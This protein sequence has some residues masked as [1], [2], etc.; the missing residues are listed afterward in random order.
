MT[1]TLDELDS[2]LVKCTDIVR[3]AVD[4][5]NYKDYIL[6]LVYYKFI[7]D[8]FE[9]QYTQN[10]Q[11]YGEDFA[12][13]RN[14]YTIPVVPED[15]HWRDLRSVKTNIGES[16]NKSFEELADQNPEQADLFHTIRIR[17]SAQDDDWLGKLIEH[18]SE[19]NLNRENVHPDVLGEAFMD[20][21]R[22]LAEQEG[23]RG[24]AFFTPARIVHLCVRLV[25]G[26]NEGE[27]FH[28]PTVG[29][30]RML[31]E[32]A[33]YYRE[34]QDGTP[35]KLTFTGQEIN[36]AIAAIAEM[37]LSVHGLNG[38][39]E[40]GNS[41]L[42]P[43]FT[44]DDNELTRFDRVL[45][46][47][48]FS[49]DW[50]KDDLQNDPYG[51][52]DWDEKLPRADRGDYAFIMH[53]AK[54]LKR[55]EKDGEGGKAAIAIPHG[56]LFRK[57][58]KRYRRYMLEHDMVEAIIG[59]PEKLFQ[60]TSIPSAI[61][62]LNT[63][64]P[65]ERKGEVQFIHAAQ[66][67]FYQEIRNQN[68]LTE[69]GIS[70][71]LRKFKNWADEWKISH[72]A[73]IEEMRKSDYTLNISH[74]IPGVENEVTANAGLAKLTGISYDGKLAIDEA[75]EFDSLIGKLIQRLDDTVLVL[76]SYKGANKP[77]LIRVKE[78]LQKMGYD[79][80]LYEDLPDF[81]DQNLSGSVATTMRLAGFCI[82]VDREASGHIDEYRI[83]EKQR[84]IL[85]RLVP[86]KGGSTRMIGGSELVDVNYIKSFRFNLEPQE[87]LEDA[88]EW[89]V[90]LLDR[91][92]EA[93][94]DHYDWRE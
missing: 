13:R 67:D 69:E 52:F 37:S 46:N 21:V 15:H 59:L 36:P 16:L 72:V 53:I 77:E 43:A 80:H 60:N 19:C 91:R 17:T 28:D 63:D 94:T 47:F 39:I 41:L 33:K 66:S 57:R 54:Q 48:P 85:A 14:L 56:V 93:Y 40:S 35:S 24:G 18:L 2:H 82:M 27:T 49:A 3:G 61:L 92:K 90:D 78:K 23:M 34:E 50:P 71:I 86:E 51:R 44:D 30:G 84:T 42:S 87:S 32:V 38:T 79:A 62:V 22:R 64:K 9:R 68:E 58:E 75:S 7:S 88:V 31:T 5:T 76:G 73:T 83:A 10:V 89:A 65:S 25:N 1:L 20:L 11:E 45:A 8:E 81:P 6:P 4:S 29:T 12:Y 74:Y 55:P 70:H 26:F